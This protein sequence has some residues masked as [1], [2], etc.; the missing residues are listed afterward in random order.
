MSSGSSATTAA[1]RRALHVGSVGMIL[2]GLLVLIGS[3]LPWV[4]TPLG[5][6]SGMGGGGLWTLSAGGL[7]IA[8]ALLPFRGVAI[9]HAFLSGAV[10]A[11]FV[12]W[13]LFRLA[14][15]SAATDSW[16]KLLPGVGLVAIGGGAVFLIRAGLR[17]RAAR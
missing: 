4:S 7:A 13:Q 8:G 15:L 11:G 2:G 17:V 12:A 9:T 5:N 16:G 6:L 3:V 10:A 1:P 14:Q